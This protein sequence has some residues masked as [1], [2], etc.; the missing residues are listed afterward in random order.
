MLAYAQQ[1][2]GWGWGGDNVLDDFKTGSTELVDMLHML[3]FAQQEGWGPDNVLDDFKTGSTEQNDIDNAAP[4]IYLPAA[5]EV[6]DSRWPK[7]T[8]NNN[9]FIKTYYFRGRLWRKAR[10]TIIA[11]T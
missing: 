6:E 9:I 3:A 4:S 2:W 7:S 10:R 11:G 1:G 8:T 5:P